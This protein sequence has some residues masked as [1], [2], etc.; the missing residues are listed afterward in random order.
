M[1]ETIEVSTRYQC[2]PRWSAAEK[3]ALVRKTYEPGLMLISTINR[4]LRS[5]FIAIVGGEMVFRALPLGTHRW[6][7]FVRPNE[8]GKL[9]GACGLRTVEQRGMAYL[10]VIHR[11][12]WTRGMAV[13][14][15]ASYMKS[16]A[17]AV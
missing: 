5:Y 1:R 16:A 15:I 6:A 2:R 12:W 9:A 3:A 7:Q 4:T 17:T 14:Y 10:P 8:L 13:N 11:V